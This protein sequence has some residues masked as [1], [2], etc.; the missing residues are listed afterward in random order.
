MYDKI[1]GVM[2][3]TDCYPVPKRCEVLDPEAVAG[4][5]G[6]TLYGTNAPIVRRL[7]QV[8]VFMTA[9]DSLTGLTYGSVNA[10]IPLGNRDSYAR[11][12]VLKTGRATRPTHS[13]RTVEHFSIRISGSVW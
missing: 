5:L 3:K 1:V 13:R 12:P 11:K 7:E 2:S 8:T 6:Y 4:Y 10:Q 9:Y